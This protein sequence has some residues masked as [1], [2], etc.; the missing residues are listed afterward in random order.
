VLTVIGGSTDA[1]NLANVELTVTPDG[2]PQ[3][4][5]DWD[6]TTPPVVLAW[7]AGT[8]TLQF[9]AARPATMQAGHRICLRGVASS[10][11]GAPLVIEALTSTDSVV[12]QTA[13]TNNPAATDV[14]YAGG[15]LTDTIRGAIVAHLNGDVLYAAATGPLAG[16]VAASTSTSVAQLQVLATGIGTANPA[17]VYGAWVGAL[18]RGT[19][20]KIATY[21]RGVRSTNVVTPGADQEAVDYAF[22]LDSQIG[23]LTPGYVLVRRG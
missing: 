12:L 2:L 3:N 22:P 18:L 15:P 14:V 16:A 20:A 9:T 4:A 7:T 23:L 8:R 11:D 10:Q 21:T 5:F 1:A 6:D 13:P 19:L 17:G